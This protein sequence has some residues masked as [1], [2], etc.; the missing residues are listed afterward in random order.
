MKK[1][2]IILFILEAALSVFAE[3][4]G[5]MPTSD[6]D[7]PAV[8]KIHGKGIISIGVAADN[9]PFSYIDAKGKYQGYDIYF[10]RQ[11]AKEILGSPR[12]VNFVPV[13]EANW[14]DLLEKDKVDIVIAGFAATEENQAL[15]DFALPYRR[16]APGGNLN[17][18][19]AVKKGNKGLV[20]WLNDV[21]R[22]RV[23]ETFF[24]KNYKATLRSFYGNTVDPETLIIERGAAL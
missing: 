1:L 11:V 6:H 8:H 2:L 21:I 23:G 20:Y 13:T 10:A 22:N 15:A 12:A 16:I 24:H 5:K 17:A 9:K 19:A 4:S 7:I 18:A 14:V 3:E